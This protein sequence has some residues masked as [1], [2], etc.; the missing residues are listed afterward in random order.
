LRPAAPLVRGDELANHLGVAPGPIIGRA[1]DAIAERQYAGAVTDAEGA[2][3][4]AARL[5]AAGSLAD[6]VSL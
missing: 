6:P 2:L 4:L 5:H 1:L 3:E